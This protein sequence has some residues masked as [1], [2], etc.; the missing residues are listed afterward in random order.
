MFSKSAGYRQTLLDAHAHSG[1]TKQGQ[2]LK[3]KKK[4]KQKQSAQLYWNRQFAECYK[5][6]SFNEEAVKSFN[7]IFPF[8]AIYTHFCC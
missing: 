7:Q 2:P 3:N 1:N 8:D 5:S 6:F 4:K